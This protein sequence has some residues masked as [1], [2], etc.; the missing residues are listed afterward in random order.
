MWHFPRLSVTS[1]YSLYVHVA[2]SSGGNSEMTPVVVIKKTDMVSSS[3]YCQSRGLH[4]M[5]SMSFCR[6]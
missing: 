6:T 2:S 1:T 4:Y 3:I 5:S